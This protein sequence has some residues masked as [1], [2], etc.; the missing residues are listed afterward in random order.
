MVRPQPSERGDIS[1]RGLQHGACSQSQPA[2]CGAV[3]P[4]EGRD[5]EDSAGGGGTASGRR[6]SGHRKQ[7]IH[8]SM[9][10]CVSSR[11]L[12]VYSRCSAARAYRPRGA[13]GDEPLADEDVENFNDEGTSS[14]S[15]CLGAYVSCSTSIPAGVRQGISL[16][17]RSNSESACLTYKQGHHPRCR[18]WIRLGLFG[19]AIQACRRHH[20]RQGRAALRELVP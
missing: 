16:T 5:S 7:P 2:N 8:E 4:V 18:V 14:P 3:E 20:L 19:P 6:H 12:L 11:Q 1:D 10:N 9:E 17:G 13:G 15:R